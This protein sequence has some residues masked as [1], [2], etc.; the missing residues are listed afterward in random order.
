MVKKYIEKISSV[1]TGIAIGISIVGFAGIVAAN[2]F[3]GPGSEP[4][5]GFVSPVFDGLTVNGDVDFNPGTGDNVTMKDVYIDDL[6]TNRI[7]GCI[8]CPDASVYGNN[9]QYLRISTVTLDIGGDDITIGSGT[10]NTGIRMPGHLRVDSIGATFERNSEKSLGDYSVGSL[11][12]GYTACP[13][14][15][16]LLGCSSYLSGN[17]GTA[18]IHEGT[19]V[20]HPL[21]MCYGYARQTKD[22][23]SS[24][25]IKVQANCWDLDNI[26]T[27]L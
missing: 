26:S 13:T 15:T 20:Y 16:H 25:T 2:N 22:P 5:N 14:G 9:S 17:N 23:A 12:Y 4:P 1:M 21:N 24:A 7:E 11:Q 6:Q 3:S 27:N 18:Y 10:V 19:R 8:G